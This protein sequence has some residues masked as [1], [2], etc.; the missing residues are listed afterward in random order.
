ML[1]QQ[2]VMKKKYNVFMIKI[3]P[4]EVIVLGHFTAK[5]DEARMGDVVCD[6]GLGSETLKVKKQNAYE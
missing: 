6:Y 4:H 3:Y 5:I 1:Q 2:A